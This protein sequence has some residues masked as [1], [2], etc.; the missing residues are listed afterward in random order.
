MHELDSVRQRM[1]EN[2]TPAQRELLFPHF[3]ELPDLAYPLDAWAWK[4]PMRQTMLKLGEV[5]GLDL[6]AG[7]RLARRFVDA[8]LKDVSVKRYMWPCGNWDG[9]TDVEKRAAEDYGR[10]MGVHLPVLIR[11]LGE[12]QDV[13][14]VEEVEAAA[15]SAEKNAEEWE[16]GREF[17]WFYVVSGR[18]E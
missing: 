9:Y 13:V 7:R 4:E 8:G 12:A 6:Q 10:G 14:T 1:P 16:T 5:K 11:K 17:L 15:K 2:V 3:L 18:K